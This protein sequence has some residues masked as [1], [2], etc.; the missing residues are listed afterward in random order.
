MDVLI[1]NP[2]TINQVYQNLGN[3]LAAIETPIWAGLLA[4]FLRWRNYDVAVLDA[5]AEG[6]MFD[7]TAQRI[8]VYK[9]RL[10]VITVY[11]HQP[12]AS[13]QNMEAASVLART[14]KTTEPGSKILLVGN[15]ISAL[16]KRTLSEE[17]A[18][19]VCQGEGPYTIAGLLSINMNDPVQY[20]KVPGLWYR[21]NGQP[22]FSYPAPLVPQ[23]RLTIELPGVAYDLLPMD[24]YR[25]H[26]WHCFGAIQKRQPYASLYTSLGCPF[27]CNF[28]CINA[29]FG[30]PGYR[31][32]EPQLIVEQFDLLALKHNVR[33]IKIADELF[34]LNENH[35]LPICKLLAERNHGLNIWAYARVDTIKPAYLEILKTAGVNWLALGIESGSELVRNGVHKGRFGQS[36]IRRIVRQIQES[37]INVIGNFIFGLPD[38]NY[39][40][41][42]E[43]L[44]L[45][46]ELNCEMV[47]FY[48][49]MAYPGSQLYD[50]A[51]KNDWQLPE[52]WLGYSQHAYETFPLPTRHLTAGQVLAFRDYAWQSYFTN[53]SYL[54]FVKEKFGWETYEHIVKMMQYSLSRK[55]AD[56]SFIP[57]VHA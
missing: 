18:D 14:I 38:D 32:W 1:I 12:S 42:Q 13:T 5:E 15:H 50:L 41:M 36:E 7:E 25:A 48:S 30:K 31:Y 53:P 27:R 6:L 34:V 28:C 49:A 11:G 57:S 8:P 2:N 26:N 29:V 51:S 56:S 45:A 39:D 47:N 23:K 35:F 17:E 24:K 21:M 54:E 52:T 40:T 37:G 33:N 16:P 9:P 43:T 44:E 46:L 19:F 3:Q 22:Y 55:Y 4:N 20:A 10:I